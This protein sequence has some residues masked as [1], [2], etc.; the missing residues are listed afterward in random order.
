MAQELR[1]HTAL[2]EKSTGTHTSSSKPPVT[3]TP[4]RSNTS[5]LF[6]HLYSTELHTDIHELKIIKISRCGST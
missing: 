1:A 5:G 2:P 6:R 3:P 4:G